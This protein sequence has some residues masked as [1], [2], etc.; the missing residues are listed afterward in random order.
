MLVSQVSDPVGPIRPGSPF[1]L[2]ASLVDDGVQFAVHAPRAE[3]LQVCLIDAGGRERRIDLP[4]LTGG[5]WHGI[6]SG[7]E[8]GQ[9]YGYR[10]HGP[11][12]PRHGLRFNSNKLLLDPSARRITGEFGDPDALLGHEGDPFG[13]P[14]P[15]DSLGHIPLSVV[16]ADLPVPRRADRLERAWE[17]TVLIEVHVASYT[18]R[19]PALPRALR[20]TYLGLAADPV[21]DHF[22]D[23][24]VTAVELLPV[25]AIGTEP[26]VRARGM[27]N[28]W[29]YSTAAFFAPHPGYA[30]VPGAEIEEFRE[31]VD[32]M[33]GA[34]IEVI[35]DVVYNHTCE[36]GVDG[37]TVCW[38]GLDAP[39]YYQLTSSGTDIDLTGCGNTVDAYSAATVRMVCDS[40][41]YW[42]EQMGVDGFRFDL[43]PALGRDGGGLF[44]DRASLL[45]AI[46]ADPV[47]RRCKLIAEPWDVTGQGYQLGRF[48]IA[49]SEWNDRFRD[50]VRRFW[51]G[52]T[53]VR[54][55]ASRLAG[56]EDVF[57]ANRRPWCSI[58]FV[59]AHD[60]FTLRDV[61]S[62]QRKHNEVNGEGNRDGSDNNVSVNHGH[63]GPTRDPDVL[64]ARAR[65]QRALLATLLLSTG[66]PMLLGGDE[67]GHTQNGNNNAYCVPADTSRVDAWPVDWMSADTHLPGYVAALLRLRRSA[68][69]LRQPEFFAGRETAAGRRDLVWYGADGKEM[70]QAGWYDD[71]RRALQMWIDGS[72]VRS[73]TAAGERLTDTSWS[74]IVHSGPAAD[75]VL[76]APKWFRGMLEPVFDSSA[77]DG[78][79]ADPAPLLPG[80]VLALT[81]PTVLALRSVESG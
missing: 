43:A 61:V 13:A 34:G 39:G 41:R 59:T 44:D 40:L 23:L 14:S 65:H 19:H 28:H 77:L 37:P 25:Q 50:D 3:R 79:P 1:P 55:I 66:T 74:I 72:G 18:A 49:W 58:N 78:T 60:G 6:V 62:Y 67:L 33:H 45:T 48:G 27:R 10:A 70:D 11:W 51:I 68:P 81:G 22:T 24:G 12:Q 64:Q 31:M 30:S 56:S 21:L 80:A 2:G 26:S 17:E 32:R 46:I 63:E 69:A 54:H 7:V 73:H 5:I 8:L 29:G 9:H 42:V 4:Q 38:R 53:G 75:I 15:R 57:G 36:A 47:L 20:G 35:L 16:T 71:S 52:D 76:A